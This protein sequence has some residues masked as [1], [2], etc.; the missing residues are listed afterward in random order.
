MMVNSAARSGDLR[1]GAD[2][3]DSALA[4]FATTPAPAAREEQWAL[5]MAFLDVG[6]GDGA[7]LVASVVDVD[8]G[9]MVL[10]AHHRRY[11]KW[12]PLGGHVENIDASLAAAAARELLE[13]AALAAIVLP[14]PLDV[15]LSSYLCR[16]VAEPV[17][18]LDVRFAA[19]T[20]AHAPALVASNELMG[21]EWFATRSLPVPRAPDTAELVTLAT[22][23]VANWRVR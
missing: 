3:W 15:C 6:H 19:V 13:E 16:T 22:A 11:G 23:A 1:P 2:R 18:H 12:G 4:L 14:A 10:L 21:L 17:P 8:A 20:E 7:H 5:A 9:G